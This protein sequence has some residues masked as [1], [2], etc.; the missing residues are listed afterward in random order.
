VEQEIRR[1]RPIVLLAEDE[2]I[3]AFDLEVSLA[4]AGFDVAG[5]FATCAEAQAWWEVNQPQAA[6]LDYALKDGP[7]DALLGELSE[8]GVPV[9][10]LTAHEAP[11]HLVKHLTTATWLL[12][13]VALPI[14]LSELKRNVSRAR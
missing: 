9:I 8:A 6:I 4:A 1:E 5:P 3:I 11:R 2:A 14:L 13:P 7:C 10:I 12:K